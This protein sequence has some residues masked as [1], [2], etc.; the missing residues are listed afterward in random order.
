[1]VFSEP[2]FLFLYLPIALLAIALTLFVRRGHSATLLALSLTFYFWSSGALTLLLIGCVAVNWALARTIRMSGRRAWLLAGVLINLLPLAYYK[3]AHFM[4]SQIDAIAGS[5]T[6]LRFEGV[7]LPIGISF[8]AFQ[9]LSYLV[10]VARGDAEPEPSLIRFGAYLTFFPQ[11][12]AGPIVR[13]RDA[14]ESYRAPKRDLALAAYGVRRFAHGLLKKIVI[15]DTVASVADASFALQPDALTT[16]GAWIGAV[17]YS[18]QIYF[19]FS[20]YSDMAIGLAALCGIH[21]RENFERPYASASI[22]EFWRRWHISLSSWF[23][24]YLYIPLGGN[25]GSEAR[26]YAN[27]F[28]VFLA[29]GLWHGAAWSFVAWGLYQGAFLILERR[30]ID[31]DR[32]ASAG[33]LS[34]FAYTLPVTVFGWVLFRAETLAAGVDHWKTMLIPTAAPL[35]LPAPIA[36]TLTPATSLVLAAACLCFVMPRHVLAATLLAG[37][38]PSSLLGGVRTLYVALILV[39]TGLLALSSDFSPFLYF[40]F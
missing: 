24:D 35:S 32:L 25:R 2:I 19:D 14:I 13:Y 29:T 22:T 5:T 15:A 21:L 31:R 6:A 27:L 33:L 39:L 30:F 16:A 1:M 8:F 4:A 10:D 7:I 38:A 12:I 3:Y 18:I 34:R 9:G 36:Q 17:A 26:T 11:L 23:R 37:P 40:R 28:L 20:G